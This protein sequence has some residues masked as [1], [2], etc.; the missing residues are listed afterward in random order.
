MLDDRKEVCN[1]TGN[2]ELVGVSAPNRYA[3]ENR[4]PF[5]SAEVRR[6]NRGP[7]FGRTLSAG[8]KSSAEFCSATGRWYPHL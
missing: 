8:A 3:L 2:V 4:F 5:S 7:P 1:V 6:S